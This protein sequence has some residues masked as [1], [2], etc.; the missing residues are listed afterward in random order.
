MTHTARLVP[1]IYPP[2]YNKCSYK[3]NNKPPKEA[4][5]GGLTYHPRSFAM[6]ALG[7]GTGRKASA[8]RIK[9]WLLGSHYLCSCL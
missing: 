9:T 2:K 7:A 4:S 1:L 3:H 6:N 5:R 8:G